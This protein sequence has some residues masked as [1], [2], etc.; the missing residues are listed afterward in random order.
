MP[1]LL[2]AL[3]VLL[4]VLIGLG[5]LTW[6]LAFGTG[7]R[8]A[9]DATVPGLRAP[10]TI[11]Y[12]EHGV[13]TIAAQSEA[14]LIAGLGYVHALHSAWPMALWQQA[15]TGSL[16]AWFEDSTALALDRHASALGFGA[17]A[18]AT[19]TTL[20]EDEKA[21]LTAY[22]R[23]VNRA[24]D[25][26]RLSEGDEFVMLD[27][28]SDEWEP[29]D[30]LAVERLI[31]Y[32]ATPAPALAD[33]LAAATYRAS[34]ALRAWVTAD[35]TFRHTLGISGLEHSLAFTFGDS[36]GT[37]FVQRHVTGT[38][39]LPLLREVILR[40]GART[41]RVASIPGTLAF[42]AGFGDR[43]W[44]LFL[45]GAAD[46]VASADT[47][48]PAPTYD[49]I[50]HRNG[51]E[52]L[53]TVYREPGA[54]V[55]YD[56]DTVA[57]V[58]EPTI[59]RD[60]TG[61]AIDTLAAPPPQRWRVRWRGFGFGTD[62]GAWRALLAGDEPT[63]GL[64]P[65]TGIVVERDGQARVLGSPAVVQALPSGVFA[66][67]H[68]WARYVAAR[69]TVL[70]D[71]VEIGPDGLLADAYSTWAA[72]LAPPLIRA[73]G[74]PGEGEEDLRDASAYLRG[75]DYR[76]DPSSVGA[77]IFSRW[78]AMHREVTGALP[79]PVAVAAPAL[80]PDSLGRTPPQPDLDAAKQ[81]L[82]LALRRMQEEFGTDWAQ[83]RWQNVQETELT[84][85]FF[86]TEAGR[87]A[88]FHVP[89]GGH[90]TALAWGP[91]AAFSNVSTA[92]SWSAWVST[93]EWETLHLRRRNL[94]DTPRTA[95]RLG[96]PV[97]PLTVRSAAEPVRTI[98]LSP[99]ND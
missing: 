58:P 12:D 7:P 24:F 83:W 99:D 77:S 31:A 73:L 66:G 85:P 71:T 36:T 81:T 51:D 34:P 28:R 67:T 76:Y 3:A 5:I 9:G 21:L 65:G 93:A 29:W 52:T 20:G 22:A 96:D 53:V 49:R 44:S 8:S 82:R 48:A 33:S 32:L 40:Q 1:R 27:V 80:P 64:F 50:V 54:L 35:S 6:Y 25:Q 60:S 4:L 15:A 26:A 95:L 10:V 63:F 92:A 13:P 43:A 30:A 41:T 17:F 18:R 38:S 70:A 94:Y 69:V 46:L 47:T 56:P 39:A 97:R 14:D 37:T 55:L 88:P 84:Y 78:M 23:G 79:D 19:Y 72:D 62:L 59:L 75:W 2:T 45:S 89:D 57:P 91:A 42:P 61:R 68:P 98:Q 86:D 74:R 11:S 90:P 16:S 87:F